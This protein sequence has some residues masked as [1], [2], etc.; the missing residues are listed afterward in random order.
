MRQ[1]ESNN[2]EFTVRD[3]Y[4]EMDVMEVVFWEGFLHEEC[5]C[6][7]LV[8]ISDR[9]AMKHGMR[10]INTVFLRVQLMKSTEQNPLSCSKF[11]LLEGFPKET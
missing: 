5:F 4:G 3:V 1:R 11:A 2:C 10:G 7:S 6:C 8:I 9:M